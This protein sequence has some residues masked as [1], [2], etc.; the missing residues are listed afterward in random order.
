MSLPVGTKP[1]SP[2]SSSI[3][4]FFPPVLELSPSP[5]HP[6]S[7]VSPSHL[8]E[9]S[10]NTSVIVPS[11]TDPEGSLP[12]TT[13]LAT[14]NKNSPEVRKSST[15]FSFR[16]SR[17]KHKLEASEDQVDSGYNPFGHRINR[18]SVSY[19][20]HHTST[21]VIYELP[22]THFPLLMQL[23]ALQ[24]VFFSPA[25]QPSESHD[26]LLLLPL[27]IMIVLPHA[28]DILPHPLPLKKCYHRISWLLSTRLPSLSTHLPSLSTRLPP[29][30]PPYP[31]VFSPFP[32]QTPPGQ[33]GT[34]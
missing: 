21:S 23:S 22:F 16:S 7:S 19:L 3:N 10:E 17:T 13:M 24:E 31:P 29:A 9:S 12:P 28:C 30:S 11:H 20:A 26:N 33:T 6:N 32:G 15:N 4:P 1:K 18:R 2:T 25:R 27:V 8:S 34:A 5:S 14:N